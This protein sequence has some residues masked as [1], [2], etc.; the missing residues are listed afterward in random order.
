[1]LRILG[2]EKTLCDGLTHRDLLQAGGLGVMGLGL[3]DLLR[4]NRVSAAPADQKLKSSFGKAKSCILLFL[5]GSPSQLETFDVKSDAPEEIRGE[6]GTIPSSIPGYRVGE[7]LPHTSQVMHHLTTVRSMTH[8]YPIHGVAYA[9]TGVPM[10]DVPMELNTRDGRHWPYVGSVVDYIDE[11]N[12][13]GVDPKIPRNIA[14]PWPFSTR[15]KGEVFRAGP[16]A[17][18]L[19]PAYHPVWTQFEGE[20]T[21]PITKTLR[22]DKIEFYDPYVGVKP[23]C[24]FTLS[25]S[26]TLPQD[27]TLDRMNKRRNL[28][29]QF[30]QS[31]RNW[32]TGE[33][34]RS[35]DRFQD[36]AFSLLTS[37]ELG[38]ALDIHQEAT[39]VR[40]SY[41]MSLFGQASLAA[42]RLVESGSRLVSVFWDEFGLA[43]SG[44]DT[45]WDHY[46][47]MKVELCPGF[48]KAFA[49][50]IRDLDGRGMLDDTIVACISEHGRTPKIAKVKGGGRDHWSRAY[51]AVF[52]GGGFAAGKI[53]GKTD[54]IA[55]DV[56]ETPVSPK[57]VLATIYHL[58]GIDP[59][60]IVY[61]R[62]G[63]PLPIAGD[64]RVRPELLA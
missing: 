47:R 55:G 29:E 34:G 33:G 8:P 46:P 5:Y 17:A 43:G 44:W 36:M 45:H 40:E 21:V 56:I 11:R 38:H 14:L 64:G 52:A 31:R 51:S 50:L 23:D 42:R 48:D 3:S 61:D 37:T 27:M 54:K 22:E 25:S 59:E 16:Y 18:F 32:E 41:G 19:G 4:L 35:H 13:N 12:A 6:L 26:G 53:V 62:L 63:R 30:E 28:L 20:G 15:R 24:R 10:I 49:G 57:D 9:T 2:S 39:P 1:M 60:T 58:L 7:L